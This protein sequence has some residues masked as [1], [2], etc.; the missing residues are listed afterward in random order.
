MRALDS[1]I[2]RVKREGFPALHAMPLERFQK[3]L[4]HGGV[5]IVGI[6][7]VNILRAEPAPSYILRA[8]QSVH[9]SISSRS[10]CVV[11]CRKLC[12]MVQYVDRWLLH[13]LGA[14]GGGEEIGC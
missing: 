2:A 4:G 8:A 13:I 14:L 3:K 12:A 5:P 10:G 1:D 9:S 6:K 11:R 7:D